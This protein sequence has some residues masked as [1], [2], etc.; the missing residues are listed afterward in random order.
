MFHLA[1]L[2]LLLSVAL[3]HLF[4]YK[5]N[6][7]L[8]EG[9]AFSN[10]VTAYDTWTPGALADESS[11]A[12]FTVTLD[13]LKVRYQPSGQQ[14]GAPRDFEA[15]VRYT[16]SPDAAEKSYVVRVNHPLK[17][18]GTKVFL[19]GNGYAP[20]FTVRDRDGRG[21]VAR[22]RCRSCRGTGTTRRSACSRSPARRRRSASTASSCPPR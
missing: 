21:R 19:L 10:T 11:L 20:V 9:E 13:D 15:S 14:R 18:D 3:G 7:L 16:S 4:G 22:R 6:V 2:L 1:L 12:P 5:A 8:I 17:V